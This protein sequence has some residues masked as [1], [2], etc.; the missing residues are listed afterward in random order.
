MAETSILNIFDVSTREN[1]ILLTNDTDPDVNYFNNSLIETNYFNLS[2]AS[3]YLKCSLSYFSV[4][5]L[6][7][8]SMRKN[9]ENLKILLKNLN[10]N[11]SV[12]CLTETWCQNGDELNSIYFLYGYNSIHQTRKN[13]I[14]GGVCIFI[15]NSFTFRNSENLSVNDANCESLTIEIIKQKT[16]SIF[17]TALYRPPNGNFDAFEK[18]L[19]NMLP[20][21]IKKHIYLTGDFNIDISKVTNDS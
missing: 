10:F 3:V 2:E 12:I 1:T 19:K 18:H 15:L 9:F 14:G 16:K 11:F 8:R 7:I 21:V 5:N 20:I 6:N 13:G 4:L 17:I